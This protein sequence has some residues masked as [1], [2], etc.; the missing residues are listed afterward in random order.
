MLGK[1][2]SPRIK[3]IK[4]QW[5]YKIDTTREYGS[6]HRLLK[7][8]KHT[9]KMQ[10]IVDQWDRMRQFY[11]SLAA[12]HVTAS[13]ALKRLSAFT[14]KNA[15]YRANV[16]LGRVF[17]TEHILYWMSDPAKR[18]RARRGLLKVEQIHQLARDI[19]YGNRGR[20]KGRSLEE[21]NSS[22]NCTTLIM[23]SI[24]YW[25]AKEISR[26][27]KEHSPE[28]AGVDLSLLEHI[29]PIG[30]SNVIIY[31]DYALNNGLVR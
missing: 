28:T 15:F 8:A 29:S 26:V 2:F 1:K 24:I 7:G 17:K 9:I 3:N 10:C 13:T 4:S 14:E 16:E 20:L 6:L 25:Q 21:I 22:G 31:G 12:G 19:T 23:A 30:W 27:V 18:K 11:A 5:L